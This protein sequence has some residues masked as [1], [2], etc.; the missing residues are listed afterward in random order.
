MDEYRLIGES[1]QTYVSRTGFWRRSGAICGV[2][3]EIQASH[4]MELAPLPEGKTK[5]LA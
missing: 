5:R 4:L 1:S 3:I 2:G